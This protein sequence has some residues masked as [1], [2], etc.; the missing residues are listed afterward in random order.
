MN[1]LLEKDER[2]YELYENDENI[3]HDLK[4]FILILM[5]KLWEN[6]K[7]VALIIENTDIKILREHLA[8]FFVHNF[9]ENIFSF[10]CIED[11]LLYVLTLLMQSEI[12][13]LNDINQADKFL[14]DTPCGIMFEEI[15]NKF[16]IQICL[17]KITKKAIDNLENN[18][19][20][21]Q[22]SYDI[23]TIVEELK[24]NNILTNETN[25]GINKI[26]DFKEKF[27]I[28]F[29]VLYLTKF[30]EE[31]KNNNKDLTDFLKTKLSIL[32]KSKQK[33]SNKKL[34]SILYEYKN[35]D[36][37]IYLYRHNFYIAIDFIEQIFKDILNKIHSLPSSIKKLCRIISELINQKFQNID[38]IN[39]HLYIAKFFF[40]KLIIPF[41]SNKTF[42]YNLNEN[43][44]HNLNNIC[45]I[46][47]KYIS[48]DLFTSD[49][50]EFNLTPF[51]LY[52]IHNIENI[53]NLFQNITKIKLPLF[54]EKL[55]NNKLPIEYEYDYF[56]E[57]PDKNAYMQSILYN[58]NQV[59][60]LIT[61][62]NNNKQ[63]LLYD[64]K[65]KNIKKIID[66]LMLE[67]NL[68][69]LNKMIDK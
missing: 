67:N 1:Q 36:K 2:I 43:S 26:E 19:S 16:E 15:Y 12:K 44:F 56:N 65:N 14:V 68:N 21:H 24:K 5:N 45:Y 39:K 23:K 52:I 50:S 3:S 41:L 63:I 59:K 48:F 11:N 60:A 57:N 29:D 51:N 47:K 64:N 46:L 30:I 28:N 25:D 40:G 62:F 31:N 42:F 69:L 55:I 6:P 8:Q 10:D 17:D 22:I 54:I 20:N 61:T 18:F 66:K 58:I 4:I 49:D 13:N 35:A 32:S 9:Y 37:L 33:F 27:L 38:T 34:L 53:V 7:L